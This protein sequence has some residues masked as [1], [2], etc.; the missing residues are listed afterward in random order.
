MGRQTSVDIRGS[1]S[2]PFNVRL[3]VF[4]FAACSAMMFAGLFVRQDA[5]FEM[6]G[7]I[8]AGPLRF[9]GRDLG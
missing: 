6:I 8:A 4:W 9:P 5:D 7:T 1:I 3:V 2:L